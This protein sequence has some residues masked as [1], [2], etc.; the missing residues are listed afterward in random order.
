[1]LHVAVAIKIIQPPQYNR[2][3]SISASYH[4]QPIP[5]KSFTYTLFSNLFLT[6]LSS[7]FKFTK[8]NLFIKSR[9]G[10]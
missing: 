7:S 8:T 1:M 10:I 3:M 4:N 2:Q 5:K 9:F 6:P